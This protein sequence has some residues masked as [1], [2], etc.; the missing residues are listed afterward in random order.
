MVTMTNRLNPQHPILMV[1]DDPVTLDLFK[2]QLNNEGINNVITCNDSTN[3]MRLFEKNSIEVA[4]IDLQMP[5]ISGQV[6]L[7]QIQKIYPEIPV[8]IVTG[9][10]HI[11]TVV[12]CTKAG[13]FDYLTKP[14]NK[15]ILFATVNRAL[16]VRKAE[17]ENQQ[18]KS[19]TT[20]HCEAFKNIITRNDCMMEI[21]KTI[22]AIAPTPWPILVTGETGVGKEMIAKSIH[23]LSNRNGAFMPVN[24]AG[25]DDVLFS[26]M[27]FG[28]IKGAFTG[29]D[30]NKNGLI[31]QAAYGTLFLDEIGDLSLV[32]QVK[33]LRL[34]QEG[35]Y[36]PLGSDKS[37]KIDVRIV[38]AT[39]KDLWRLQRAGDF[40]EDLNYRLRTHHIHI[41]PLRERKE[42]LQ[43][44]VDHF[45]D[46]A[47]FEQKK[48]KPTAPKELIPLL[49]TYPFFGNIRELQALIFDAVSRHKS[50]ILSLNIFKS[51]LVRMRDAHQDRL[52]TKISESHEELITFHEK[53][54]S[55]K[56]ANRLLINEAM[57]R[58]GNNQTI[59]ATLLGI[60]QSALSKRLKD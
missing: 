17:R 38:T 52:E 23:E 1:D 41:P 15:E 50:K 10:M 43:L 33:L 21:F 13:A 42:D 30:K 60:T 39:N 12:Q 11:P 51:A 45:L 49:H 6:L 34:V 2:Q 7:H 27:L 18:L 14:P 59:A 5:K 36:I 16:R 55:L 26:D 3:V 9:S 22:Q 37:R 46:Q 35:E 29:A 53:L 28:H 8:I 54:P 19:E 20:I 4:L 32:S 24:I 25:L 48:K 44:L 58:A 56:Q 31:Q 57:R 47:A 40:R